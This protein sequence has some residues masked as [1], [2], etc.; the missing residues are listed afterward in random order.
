[1][2]ALGDNGGTKAVKAFHMGLWGKM[3]PSKPE[4]CNPKIFKAGL[5]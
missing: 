3:D 2:Y 5:V 4:T 1:L